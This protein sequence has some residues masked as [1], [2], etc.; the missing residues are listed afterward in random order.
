M[1]EYTFTGLDDTFDP[2]NLIGEEQFGTVV[3]NPFGGFTVN[4]DVMLQDGVNHSG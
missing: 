1:P 4:G 2:Y 3:A